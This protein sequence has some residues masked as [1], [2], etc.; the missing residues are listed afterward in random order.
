VGILLTSEDEYKEFLKTY[1]VDSDDK[2]ILEYN[3]DKILN[4][5]S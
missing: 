5:K 4:K 2:L 3:L 1:N